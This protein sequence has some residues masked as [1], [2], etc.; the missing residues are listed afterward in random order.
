MI[1]HACA[2]GTTS[3]FGYRTFILNYMQYSKAKFPLQ[4]T[5]DDIDVHAY[6]HA[7]CD[8]V[9]TFS[10]LTSQLGFTTYVSQE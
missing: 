5:E 9:I 8:I 3:D 6:P 1:V 2:H 4:E 10:N 7:S